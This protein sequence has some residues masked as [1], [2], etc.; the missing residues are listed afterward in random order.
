MR[1]TVRADGCTLQLSSDRA[2][3]YITATL[4]SSNKVWQSR[5]FYLRN[6]DGRLPAFTH[7]VFLGAEERWRWRLPQ[8]I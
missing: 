5:W 6:N 3:L 1:H 4:T 7:S 2:Q 8:E